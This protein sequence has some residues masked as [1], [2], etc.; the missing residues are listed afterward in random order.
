MLLL[1]F[2]FFLKLVNVICVCFSLLVQMGGLR[3]FYRSSPEIV[4]AALCV[5]IVYLFNKMEKKLMREREEKEEAM[6]KEE[7]KKEKAMREKEIK[8]AVMDALNEK[9][10]R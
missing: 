9:G 5:L 3:E 8:Q 2:F 4:L 6:R 7:E 1:L 10:I